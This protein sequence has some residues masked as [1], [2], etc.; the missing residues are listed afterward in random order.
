VDR[1]GGPVDGLGRLVHGFSFL[2]FLFDLSRWA[3][4]PPQERSIHRD[5]LTEAIVMPTSVNP[6]RPSSKKNYVVVFVVD[7]FFI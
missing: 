5:L 2:L 4:E 6:F 1:L 3:F 7:E